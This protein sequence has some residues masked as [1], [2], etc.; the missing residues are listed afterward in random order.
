M[1]EILMAGGTF[2]GALTAGGAVVAGGGDG[3]GAFLGLAPFIAGPVVFG[4]VYMGIYRYYRNTDKRHYFERETHVETY[5]HQQFN[6]RVGRR[7]RLKNRT[8]RGAN[9]ANS[10]DRVQR[11]P[12][13]P[14]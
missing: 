1:T 8:M 9:E 3:G 5:G 13:D 2:A 10:L 12:V 4:M 14:G 7:T 11:I 6:D